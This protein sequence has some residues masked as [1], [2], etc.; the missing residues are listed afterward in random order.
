MV[1]LSITKD[2]KS[3]MAERE[4]MVYTLQDAGSGAGTSDLES[5]S[6]QVRA[7]R[8]NDQ[9]FVGKSTRQMIVEP[10]VVLL[11][12]DNVSVN[13]ATSDNGASAYEVKCDGQVSISLG[14][15][16]TGQSFEL[17]F[18]SIK[19]T[20]V[21]VQLYGPYKV[22]TPEVTI[23]LS[24]FG[25]STQKFDKPLT[26]NEIAVQT[27]LLISSAHAQKINTPLQPQPD[28]IPSPGK[29]FDRDARIPQPFSPDSDG[30]FKER[31]TN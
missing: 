5:R 19:M 11:W 9:R 12:C 18:G 21:S 24:V 31:E 3:K 13:V 2:G 8:N 20:D 1:A 10:G 15:I 30:D 29:V 26:A 16:I 27:S 6:F 25:V 7:E 23:P 28:P 22:A 17:K 4:V 14:S